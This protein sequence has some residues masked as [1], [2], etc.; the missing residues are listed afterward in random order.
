MK[1]LNKLQPINHFINL[2]YTPPPAAP[3]AAPQASAEPN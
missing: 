2:Q 3:P 1:V